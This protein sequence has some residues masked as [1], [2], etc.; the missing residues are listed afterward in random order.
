MKIL[1]FPWEAGGGAK[2]IGSSYGPD[3]IETQFNKYPWRCSE[4]GVPARDV[5]FLDVKA[6]QSSSMH[7]A[8]GVGVQAILNHESSLAV[9]SGDNSC[10]FYTVMNVAKRFPDPQLVVL[11]A[12]LDACDTKHDA[13]AS[14]VR[15]LWENDIVRPEKTIFFGIRDAEAEELSYAKEKGAIIYLCRNLFINADMARI[16][17]GLETTMRVDTS[18]ALILVVDIDVVDPSQAPATGVLRAPGLDLRQVLSII[19]AFGELHFPVK[20]GEICEVIPEEGNMMRPP[21]DKRPDPTG[22]TV[23]ATEA[24]LREMICSFA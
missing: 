9:L 21:C 12:H 1:K 22:L 14:W 17:L 20:V 5:Q 13:H 8:F 15:R 7:R 19:R 11:D 10:S 4:S 16:V 23:L 18:S 2:S 6:V 24:I 3:A